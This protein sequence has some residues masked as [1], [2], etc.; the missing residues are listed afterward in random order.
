MIIYVETSAAGK[1]LV[2]ESESG[3]L[4]SFL[5]D[6]VARGDQLASCLLLETELRRLAVREELSQAAV[7]E[8]LARID[9]VE[10]D[11][12]QYRVA[13]VL[14]GRHLRSL[15]ALHVATAL[16]VAADVMLTYDV[17]QAAAAE[18][19]GV[20]TAAPSPNHPIGGGGPHS[21]GAPA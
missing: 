16:R 13:G 1:L 21:T 9:L 12:G 8:V 2:E 4:S 7:S 20:R 19:A 14:P 5:D 18:A 17:R 6:A 11:R 15:D 3:A 10:L